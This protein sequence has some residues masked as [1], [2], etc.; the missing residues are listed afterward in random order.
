MACSAY[1]HKNP[2][3]AKITTR[4]GEYKWS[5]FNIYTGETKDT[6]G[7]VETDCILKMFSD[8]KKLAINQYIMFVEEFKDEKISEVEIDTYVNTDKR[9]P[10]KVYKMED[11]LEEVCKE[12]NSTKEEVTAKYTKSNSIAK[13][14]A[15]YMMNIKCK[16][17]HKDI[18]KV[19]DICPSGV[20]HGILR[21]IELMKYNT[22]VKQK[23]DKLFAYL[24]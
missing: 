19:F 17:T 2:I 13:K 3:R 6:Y 5:S 18:A 7:I 20:G 16:L 9:Y 11:I 1:I 10:L 4:A 24:M 23:T 14:V 15:L 12:F 21:C 22:V 8:N